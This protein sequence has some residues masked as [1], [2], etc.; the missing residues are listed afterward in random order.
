DGLDALQARAGEGGCA[1]R[2]AGA[3]EAVGL[4]LV[5]GGDRQTPRRDGGAAVSRLAQGIVGGVGPG[6][7]EAGEGDRLANADIGVGE[8]GAAVRQ[9]HGVAT[10]VARQA[11]T[12]GDAVAGGG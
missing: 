8:G 1:E 3:A 6:D 9:V 10:D 12:A 4:A 11:G 5:A 7:R 2:R